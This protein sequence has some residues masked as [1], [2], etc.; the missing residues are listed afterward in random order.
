[1]VAAS[2]VVV[3]DIEW[4]I[5]NHSVPDPLLRAATFARLSLLT[6]D[7]PDNQAAALQDDHHNVMLTFNAEFAA[8]RQQFV[9]R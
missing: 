3:R 9:G 1:M 5:Q 8:W 2:Q 4:L 6:V 7:R